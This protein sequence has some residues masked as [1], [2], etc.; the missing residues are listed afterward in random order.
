MSDLI[1][2]FNALH[3]PGEPLLLFNIWDAGS[4]RAVAK[5]GA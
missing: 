1:A 3:V 5:A 4:A 2:E